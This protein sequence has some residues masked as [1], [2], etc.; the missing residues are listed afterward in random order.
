MRNVLHVNTFS[1]LCVNF[2]R[3][4]DFILWS[5]FYL[6]SCAQSGL[7]PIHVAAFMGHLNIVLLLLQNGA[8]PDVSN[9]VSNWKQPSQRAGK[10]Q[11][12]VMCEKASHWFLCVSIC[13]FL[14]NMCVLILLT[15]TMLCVVAWRN[16]V[17]HGSQGRSGGGGQVFA[18]K[19]SNG[20]CQSTGETTLY[21]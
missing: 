21:L 12:T 16:S 2:G 15:C 20:G 7:T 6:P 4:W 18:E 11:S 14:L 17:T 5:L 10:W 3:D 19:R 9:I 8:S 13:I 1:E